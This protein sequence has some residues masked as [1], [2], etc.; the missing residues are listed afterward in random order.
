MKRFLIAVL[1]AAACFAPVVVPSTAQGQI[2]IELG[3]RPYYR[4]NW[5]WGP[6]RHVRYYWVPGHWSHRWGRRVWI[7]GHYVER[8]RW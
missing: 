4:G 2:S 3:D 5:Y 7:H 1:L 8:Y 6:G